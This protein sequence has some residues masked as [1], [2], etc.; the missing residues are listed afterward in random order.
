MSDSHYNVTGRL[1]RRWSWMWGAF[2]I[3][4]PISWGVS[5]FVSVYVG[6]YIHVCVYA[7]MGWL[8]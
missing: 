7:Y 4:L 3:N 2:A 1:Q 5:M 8:R 6:V